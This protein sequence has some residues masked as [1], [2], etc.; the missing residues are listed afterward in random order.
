MILLMKKVN[1]QIYLDRIISLLTETEG[2]VIPVAGNSMEPFLKENRDQV[3]LVRPRQNEV[4]QPGEIVLFQRGNGQYVLHRIVM[5]AE[6]L[7]MIR[8]DNQMAA[9]PVKTEQVKA[10]VIRVRRNGRWM[11]PRNMIWKF[12]AGPWNRMLWLRKAAGCFHRVFHR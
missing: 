9:E 10:R 12:F 6:K 4:Y 1:T 2:A 8:G 7:L 11:T 3:Y 5:A